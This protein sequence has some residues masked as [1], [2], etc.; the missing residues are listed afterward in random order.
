MQLQ[1]QSR[2]VPP[3]WLKKYGLT[4]LKLLLRVF[5]LFLLLF[6][7]FGFLLVLGSLV[8]ALLG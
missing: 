8:L 5:Q 3:Q 7:L 4:L 2:Y 6:F 1:L